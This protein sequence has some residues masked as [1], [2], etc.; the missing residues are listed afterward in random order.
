MKPEKDYSDDYVKGYKTAYIVNNYKKSPSKEKSTTK[1]FAI[2]GIVFS[3]IGLG[4]DLW[5]VYGYNPRLATNILFLFSVFLCNL[6]NFN[7]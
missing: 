1:T 5:D 6:N 2:F 4:L 3:V 7:E